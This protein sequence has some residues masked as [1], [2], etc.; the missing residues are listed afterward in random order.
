MKRT[1]IGFIGAGEVAERHAEAIQRCESAELAGLWNRNRTRAE[2]KS[3][4]FGCRR[5]ESP[6]ELVADPSV[7]AVFVLTDLETHHRYARLALEAGKHVLIEKPVAAEASEILDLRDLAAE[8]RLCCMP[9]HNYIYDHSLRRSRELIQAGKLGTLV[10]V[11]ILYNIAH[12]EEIAARYPGVIKQIMTHHAYILL[13]LA[14]SPVRL[15]AMKSSLHYKSITQED[16]AMVNLQLRSGA[17]AHFGASFAADDHSGDPWTMIV[18]VL[19]TEGATH[20]SYRD[21]VEYRRGE[22]HSLTY[23][24]YPESI[25]QEVDHFVCR[26][27]GRGEPPL[28]TLDDALRAHEIVM[29]IE[30]GAETGETINL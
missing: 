14:G 16:I 9:G 21:S 30:Q 18:K 17:L 2:E 19:G 13:Y 7:D 29:A 27:I 12:A 26:C 8:K 4:R 25:C 28:S 6:E 1:R 11:H 5:Y 3:A 15:S 20:Y 23:T 22:A 24:A 10:S